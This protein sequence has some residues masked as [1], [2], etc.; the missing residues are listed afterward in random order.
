MERILATHP[1][2][3]LGF[4]AK[5]VLLRRHLTIWALWVT[6]GGYGTCLRQRCCFHA[7][8]M[9]SIYCLVAAYVWQGCHFACCIHA[10]C[11]RNKCFMHAVKGRIFA[12]NVQTRKQD[13][14]SM[15]A[16][17]MRHRHRMSL[18]WMRHIDGKHTALEPHTSG[19]DAAT[20]C[21]KDAES[22]GIDRC[23]MYIDTRERITQSDFH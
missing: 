12:A 18:G 11:V 19:S 15:E 7:A 4:I 16:V 5:N 13:I 17:N 21:G 22:C 3:L 23:C 6:C 20:I 2:Q 8:N 10:A 14:N 1:D 9:P